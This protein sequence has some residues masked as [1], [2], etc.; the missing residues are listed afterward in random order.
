MTIL[1]SQKHISCLS[2]GTCQKHVQF[3][4]RSPTIYWYVKGK[5]LTFL[6][7][8]VLNTIE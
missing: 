3:T 8:A 7:M 1:K 4:E 5:K 6:N 2:V